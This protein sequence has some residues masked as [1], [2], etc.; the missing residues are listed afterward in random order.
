MSNYWGVSFHYDLKGCNMNIITS[1]EKLKEW[2][3]DLVE[4]ISMERHG[5]AIIEHFGTPN[6]DLEGYT[7]LQLIKTSSITL[8]ANDHTGEAYLDVF[9]CKIVDNIEQK[10]EQNIIKWFNPIH[11]TYER[12]NRKA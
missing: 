3:I 5:E 1:K 12:L 8:H 6:S 10:I 9:T 7:L 2:V 11:I 4:S